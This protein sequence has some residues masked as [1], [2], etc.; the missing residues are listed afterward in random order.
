MDLATRIG[1][2]LNNVGYSDLCKNNDNN[3][4]HLEALIPHMHQLGQKAHIKEG[5]K[6]LAEVDWD[7]AHQVGY[8]LSETKIINCDTILR[9]QCE[10][11]NKND[12][13]NPFY[14]TGVRE[15]Y[16][17]PDA[18]KEMCRLNAR[19]SVPYK[20]INP[21]PTVSSYVLLDRSDILSFSGI[22][23]EKGSMIEINGRIIR[24][25]QV[26]DDGKTINFDI[27]DLTKTF[28]KQKN[29]QSGPNSHESQ[30]GVRSSSTTESKLNIRII[31]PT[32]KSSNVLVLNQIDY[33]FNKL[34]K[35]L[36]DEN[37]YRKK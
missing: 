11:L 33:N 12:S 18:D 23:I 7:F 37:D 15:V 32:G 35:Y 25:G 3:D 22:N 5:K 30:G 28:G 13:S 31:S 6:C 9:L 21:S 34:E 14:T 8:P 16:F 29:F 27:R 1:D 26:S 19:L 2:E 24:N 20:D 4:I 17:G 10:Y 36:N